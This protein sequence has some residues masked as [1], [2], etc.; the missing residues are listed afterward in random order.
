MDK[1]LTSYRKSYEKNFLNE[2]NLPDSPFFLFSS[3]FKEVEETGGVEEVN[4]MTVT[5]TGQNG[6]PK[7]RIVLLKHYDEN[8]FV[9]YTNYDSEKG[10][11]I[12]HNNKVCISFFW[13]NLER[14][15][16]IRGIVNKIDKKSSISYF[17][18]RPRGSQLG[19]LV[20]EQS[21]VIDSREVLEERLALLVKEYENK[22]IPMP[23]SWGGYCVQPVDFEFWQGRPNRLHDR[24]RFLNITTGWKKERLSP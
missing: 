17:L 10:Q 2:E 18:S 12:A 3:W 23:D 14:Q 11:D 9:F 16:I 21:S 5:T 7:A 6:F 20:S 13:P 15:V 19:A 4:A 24:I 22:E 1:D 8:G